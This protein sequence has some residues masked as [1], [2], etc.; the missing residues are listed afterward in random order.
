MP[1]SF[2]AHPWRPSHRA[3]LLI[4]LAIL[5]LVLPSGGRASRTGHL[6]LGPEHLP[7]EAWALPEP[8]PVIHV[9]VPPPPIHTPCWRAATPDKQLPHHCS[10]PSFPL[11]PSLPYDA[12]LS[13]SSARLLSPPHKHTLLQ[14]LLFHGRLLVSLAFCGS[15][16]AFSPVSPRPFF[17]LWGWNNHCRSLGIPPWRGPAHGRLN[18]EAARFLTLVFPNLLSFS[19]SDCSLSYS[20]VFLRQYLTSD[21]PIISMSWL[22]RL[23]TVWGTG[24]RVLPNDG[25]SPSPSHAYLVLQLS[26]GQLTK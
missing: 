17:T 10:G 26:F 24:L 4:F 3:G 21:W 13:S 20:S 16:S 14:V 25:L 11:S 6:C 23:T 1:K 18:A 15:R 12:G 5:V 9:T 2:S 8:A 22:L 19:A 7:H